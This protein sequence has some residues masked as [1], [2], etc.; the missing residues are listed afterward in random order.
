MPQQ[1]LYKIILHWTTRHPAYEQFFWFQDQVSHG[2]ISFQ[3]EWASFLSHSTDMRSKL[4]KNFWSKITKISVLSK[5]APVCLQEGKLHKKYRF[6]KE[7]Y[8]LKCLGET[9]WGWQAHL[10]SQFACNTRVIVGARSNPPLVW[11]KLRQ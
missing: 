5:M 8:G 1:L 3:R 10:V 2:L 11:D 9:T 6:R 7:R 4:I